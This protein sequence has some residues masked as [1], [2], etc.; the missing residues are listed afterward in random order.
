M[1]ALPQYILKFMECHSDILC[2][3]M[4]FRQP[5]L[6]KFYGFIHIMCEGYAL[7][8]FFLRY[9]ILLPVNSRKNM[10]R[11]TKNGSSP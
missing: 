2:A 4:S 10:H 8:S 5:L 6:H 11:L 9:Q 1:I 7:T 3:K